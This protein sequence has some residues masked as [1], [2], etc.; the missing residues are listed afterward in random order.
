AIG[1]LIVLATSYLGVLLMPHLSIHQASDVIENA[2]AGAWRGPF[3]HKNGAGAMMV[4]LIFV[5]VY[6]G[7]IVNLTAGAMIIAGA[8]L[9]L[10]FTMS[11][12][13]MGL[14]LLVLILSFM[15]LRLRSAAAKYVLV[16]GTVVIANLLTVGTVTIDAVDKLITSLMPDASYTGRDEIWL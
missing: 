6:V 4:V 2:L 13:P 10:P 14:F 11:K 12:S 5:G 8:A 16:I 9:F 3:G 7:R 15:L 1:A